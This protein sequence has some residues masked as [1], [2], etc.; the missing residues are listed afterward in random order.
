MAELLGP[1]TRYDAAQI[2]RGFGLANTGVICH[3]N[4]LLQALGACPA[5][6]RTACGNRDYL[7][8]TGTGAAFY[9]YTRAVE[10]SATEPGFQVDS[11]HSAR[12]LAKLVVDLAARKPAVRFGA[13]M[14]SATEGLN[15]L[16]DMLE[17]PSQRAAPDPQSEGA[18]TTADPAAT[19]GQG[20]NPILRLFRHRMRCQIMC[21]G[22]HQAGASTEGLPVGVVSSRVDTGCQVAWRMDTHTKTPEA[23]A[24]QLRHHV[25]VLEDYRCSECTRAGRPSSKKYRVYQLLLVPPVLP[26]VFHS[27]YLGGAPPVDVPQTFAFCGK[28]GQAHSYR[29]V[30]QIEHSGSLSSGHY[31]AIVQRQEGVVRADDMSATAGAFGAT[32]AT[33]TLIY[34]YEGTEGTEATEA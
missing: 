13:S 2:P 23:F 32:G 22:C 16:L 10:S 8:R 3:F 12:L 4:S 15:L 19:S 26:I 5:V 9:N 25:S 28:N 17:P 29:L 6:T 14:E 20:S 21:A 34:H 27:R 7:V 18:T 30:A 33:Y 1:Q 24:A 11:S 31:W